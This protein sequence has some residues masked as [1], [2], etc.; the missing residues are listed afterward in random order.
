M[1]LDTRLLQQTLTD[2]NQLPEVLI[3]KPI[4][5]ST[6]DDVREV[7]L[8]GINSVLICSRKQTQGRG[9]NQRPWVSPEGN[10]YLSTLLNLQTPIDGRLALEI[11]LNIIQIPSFDALGFKVKWPNDIY[12]NNQKLGGILVEPI[13]SHQA[14]VGVGINVSS[15]KNFQINQPIT[16]LE[17]VGITVVDRLTIIA[18]LYLAIQQA[19]QWFNHNCYN[20]AAR[21]NHHAA[22]INQTI[23]FEHQSI[24]FKN[25]SIKNSGKFLGIQNDG[26]IK[27]QTQN[28]LEV[29]YQ[30]RLRLS[31]PS[32]E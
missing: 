26:S 24:E 30:G 7:A 19:G 22:F 3:L 15:V 6:N 1:D 4:T 10:I 11:A 17:E 29:F 16:S 2:V 8:K 13:S 14:V 23:E 27:I 28:G 25:G 12:F 5:T 20:L 21:F 18:E 9:Q 32:E 31:Q